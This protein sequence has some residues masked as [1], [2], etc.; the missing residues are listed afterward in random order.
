M[1]HCLITFRSI[2]PAQRGESVL[3]RSG[4]QCT[5]TRTPK[6]MEE[7]G[8]GYSLQV[9]YTQVAKCV[10]KLRADR[11]PFRK[12]YLLRENGSAEELDV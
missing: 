8:C 2:T 12:V 3:R 7:Q 6:W 5:L 11:V 1:N 9:R 10:E 4:L